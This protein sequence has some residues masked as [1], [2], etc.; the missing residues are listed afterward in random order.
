MATKKKLAFT[1]ERDSVSSTT[2]AA[3]PVTAAP[4]VTPTS[5]S[6]MGAVGR[7]EYTPEY[8][9]VVPAAPVSAPTTMGAV[10]RGEYVDVYPQ[11]EPV[12]PGRPPSPGRAWI[13]NGT[14][15]VKPPIPDNGTEKDY[16]WDD[17]TG[18]KKVSTVTTTTVVN[19]P[20]TT[21]S[22]QFAV[23]NKILASYGITGFIEALDKI[24]ADYP[25]ADS[26]T[27]LKLFQY[28]S[29]YN[30]PFL[31][32]FAA[33]KARLAAG[34]PMVNAADY[35]GMEQGYKKLF[36][37]YNL[38][39]FANQNM[40]DTLITNDIDVTEATDRVVLAYDRLLSDK[41]TLDAFKKFFPSLTNEDIVSAM[42]NP[43]EQVPALKRKVVAAEVGG[44][45]AKQALVSAYGEQVAPAGT[46]GY[47]NVSRG[48]IGAEA[49]VAAG[50]T[51]ESSAAAYQTIATELPLMEKLSSIYAYG[52]DQYGQM[53]AEQA[54]IQGLAS[55]ANKQRKLIAQE[56]ATWSGQAGT[57]KGS[58][59]GGRSNVI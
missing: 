9:G 30:E 19:P 45:A 56:E 20:K 29:K 5:T 21:Q 39:K 59:G 57:F 47:S 16:V 46:S 44:Q 35:L 31:K 10:S 17:A 55:A 4:I 15:W 12:V 43:K 48:T 36:T 58:F 38:T 22:A 52:L 50:A 23:A 8:T 34:L 7:G 24:R 49:A 18:W 33:N 26:E 13:W 37:N 3:K 11:T 25:D 6:T 1:G 42:L 14:S 41:N 28:D 54:R 27:I 53:Q 51:K 2:T 32:R 40:Y